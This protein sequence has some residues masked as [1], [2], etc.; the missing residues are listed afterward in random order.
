MKINGSSRVEIIT[1]MLIS[2]IPFDSMIQ[3][4]TVT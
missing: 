4:I 1:K 2:K 3:P